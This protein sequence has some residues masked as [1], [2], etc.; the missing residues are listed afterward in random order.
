[1]RT[2]VGIMC[3][4]H[5]KFYQYPKGHLRGEGCPTCGSRLKSKE[6]FIDDAIRIHGDKYN[7]SKVN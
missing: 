1:M 5:G 6:Q 3:F 2:K 4:I 7:Y